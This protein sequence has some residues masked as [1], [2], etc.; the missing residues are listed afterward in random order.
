MFKQR[1]SSTEEE[2]E[3]MTGAIWIEGF[4]RRE[5]LGHFIIIICCDYNGT[6]SRTIIW[7][8]KLY[9]IPDQFVTDIVKNNKEDFTSQIAPNLL[10]QLL[11]VPAIHF[12]PELVQRE[13]NLT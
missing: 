2:V 6:T 12:T 1:Y 7:E 3:N 9:M 11:L 13:N 4:I 10:H 8:S 5:S